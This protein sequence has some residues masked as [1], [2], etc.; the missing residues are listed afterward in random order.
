MGIGLF[1]TSVDNWAELTECRIAARFLGGF[2]MFGCFTTSKVSG[3]SSLLTSTFPFLYF[4][5]NIESGGG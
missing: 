1:T 2:P 3:F 5:S 4:P